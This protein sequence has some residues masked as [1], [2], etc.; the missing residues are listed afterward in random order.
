MG[1]TK[2]LLL[3]IIHGVINFPITRYVPLWNLIPLRSFEF[4]RDAL[5]RGACERVD[6]VDGN[7]PVQTAGHRHINEPIT[8]AYLQCIIDGF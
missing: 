5:Y 1:G 6:I 7:K 4:H 8:T 3:T 2:L